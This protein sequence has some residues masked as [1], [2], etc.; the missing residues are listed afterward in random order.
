MSSLEFMSQNWNVDTNARCHV[1][2]TLLTLGV[3]CCTASVITCL[4]FVS[5]VSSKWLAADHICLYALCTQCT[6]CCVQQLHIDCIFSIFP[7]TAFIHIYLVLFEFPDSTNLLV[8]I[9]LHIYFVVSFLQASFGTSWCPVFRYYWIDVVMLLPFSAFSVSAAWF[10]CCFL[11]SCSFAFALFLVYWCTNLHQTDISRCC[12]L[13][14]LVF[15]Y[16][17]F[18][19]IV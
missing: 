2:V 19:L 17:W 15:V 12:A 10:L 7:T 1:L 11:N 6:S 3:V 9:S 13:I 4:L 5:R 14:V 8:D 16:C 18:V